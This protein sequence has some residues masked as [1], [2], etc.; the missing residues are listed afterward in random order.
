MTNHM[1]TETDGP[2]DARAALNAFAQRIYQ[3]EQELRKRHGNSLGAHLQAI[4]EAQRTDPGTH[5]YVDAVRELA[6]QAVIA[7]D[8]ANHFA[9]ERLKPI[10][11]VDQVL[12]LSP[13]SHEDTLR[14][15]ALRQVEIYDDD[16][17]DYL[18]GCD[19]GEE[20]HRW[21]QVCKQ[22]GGRV[23]QAPPFGETELCATDNYRYLIITE[24]E[25]RGMYVTD[26]RPL[27]RGDKIERVVNLPNGRR[28]Y[29]Y[30][31]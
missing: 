8:K 5:L 7:E 25:R 16:G 12:R 22:H 31:Q 3:K 27:F 21:F 29:L 17:G 18:L 23:Y 1:I 2:T 30:Q 13:Y 19:N 15:L 24:D 11:S 4:A 6:R 20:L 10:I 9:S 28:F 26:A 14:L